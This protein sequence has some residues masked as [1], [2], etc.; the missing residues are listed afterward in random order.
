MTVL[1][2]KASSVPSERT[3]AKQR[4]SGYQLNGAVDASPKSSN[5]QKPKEEVMNG[6]V[7]VGNSRQ[8]DKKAESPFSGLQRRQS[9]PLMPAFVVSAPG[10]VIVFGEHAVVHGKVN[11]I[12]IIQ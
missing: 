12:R 1:N 3:A 11:P 6:V 7:P 5:I 10:K 9:T 2:S 4:Q 8:N